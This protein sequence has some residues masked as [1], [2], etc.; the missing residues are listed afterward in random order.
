MQ[1]VSRDCWGDGSSRSP[2]LKGPAHKVWGVSQAVM[3]R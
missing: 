1:K 2:L 3:G